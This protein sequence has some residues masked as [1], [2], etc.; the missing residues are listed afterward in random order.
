[1][2]YQILYE[3][4]ACQ[5]YISGDMDGDMSRACQQPL[6]EQ[7][8]DCREL[9]LDLSEVGFMDHYGIDLLMILKDEARH[10]GGQLRIKRYSRAV[11]EMFALL[12]HFSIKRLY[13]EYREANLTL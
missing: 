8:R 12:N 10:S 3:A 4:S 13:R 7:L 11:L 6:L 1:M 2:S 9:E 5:V